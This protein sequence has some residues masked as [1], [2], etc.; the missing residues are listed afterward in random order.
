M[1]LKFIV[2][3]A[4]VKLTLAVKLDLMVYLFNCTAIMI[5]KLYATPAL[6]KDSRISE[7]RNIGTVLVYFTL[8]LKYH[9]TEAALY[10]T[11]SPR[12][13]QRWSTH[14]VSLDIK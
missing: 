5:L 1:F 6:K 14:L 10:F 11:P 8:G 12:H 9:K 3:T 4:I 13:V 7:L 2:I